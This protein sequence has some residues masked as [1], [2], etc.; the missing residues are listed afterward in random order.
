MRLDLARTC[1]WHSY[2]PVRCLYL[3][4]SCLV[5]P[6]PLLAP[7]LA[8]FGLP[9]W[10]LKS[11]KIRKTNPRRPEKNLG[12][13]SGALGFH[14]G[15]PG[16]PRGPWIPLGSLGPP[17]GPEGALGSP[18]GAPK[19]PLGTHGSLGPEALRA[20]GLEKHET[21]SALSDFWPGGPCSI[22]GWRCSAKP[23][24]DFRKSDRPSNTLIA[25]RS[26]LAD[27]IAPRKPP[28]LFHSVL[29][30]NYRHVFF[31]DHFTWFS[32]RFIFFVCLLCHAVCANVVAD[33]LPTWAKVQNVGEAQERQLQNFF[34]SPGI[35][36]KDLIL[37]RLPP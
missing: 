20:G 29:L 3:P 15:A 4:S 10:L 25:P 11:T 30:W 16:S 18:P 27:L 5:L 37:R 19:G 28:G 21:T 34:L 35:L 22:V 2:C 23:V 36:E 31:F 8:R 17:K 6:Y 33:T 12:S 13:P 14:S 1:P 26:G 24:L 7:L 32:L 9:T